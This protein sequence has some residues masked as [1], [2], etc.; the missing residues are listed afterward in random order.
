MLAKINLVKNS[1]IF[2]FE[3]N[4]MIISNMISSEF[5]NENMNLKAL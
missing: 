5:F 4:E 1:M 2:K 3:S